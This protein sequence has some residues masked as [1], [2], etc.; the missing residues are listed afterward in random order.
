MAEN[1]S[2]LYYVVFSD[3]YSSYTVYNSNVEPVGGH[4]L[5]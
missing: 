4:V 5:Y 1:R 3:N 2:W